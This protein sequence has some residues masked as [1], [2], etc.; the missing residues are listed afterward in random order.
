MR[1]AV[2][3]WDVVCERQ[4]VFVIAVIPPHR[5]FNHDPVA[6]AGNP[7]RFFHDGRLGAIKIFD[8]LLHPTFIVQLGFKRFYGTFISQDDADAGI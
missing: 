3:L 1:A 6:F 2:A 8:E 4:N 7:N 5:D